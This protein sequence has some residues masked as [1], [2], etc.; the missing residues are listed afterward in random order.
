MDSCL[1]MYKISTVKLSVLYS[2]IWENCEQTNT[3]LAIKI[4]YSSLHENL[5][6][7][8]YL[9]IGISFFIS[10][11]QQNLISCHSLANIL[12]IYGTLLSR[13]Y[14]HIKL[15]SSLWILYFHTAFTP[16]HLPSLSENTGFTGLSINTFLNGR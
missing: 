12:F 7:S 5:N 2:Q 8:T 4:I 10:E 16:T 14:C 6:W 15:H 1:M 11:Y 13:W 3:S 9:V